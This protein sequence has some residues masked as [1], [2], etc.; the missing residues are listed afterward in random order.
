MLAVFDAVVDDHGIE[1]VGTPSMAG[2][3]GLLEGHVS[4]EV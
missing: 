2:I 3:P 4:L 1:V